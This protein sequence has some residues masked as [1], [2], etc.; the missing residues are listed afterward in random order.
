MPPTETMNMLTTAKRIRKIGPQHHGRKMLLKD[1]E[2]VETVDG[3]HYELSR[4]YITVSNVANFYHAIV[5]AAI[6]NYFGAHQLANPDQIFVIL[7]EMAAKLLIAEFE[8]ER[9]PD[10]AVYLTKPKG[11]KNRTVWRRWIPEIVIEVV[12]A[13]S[14]HRDYFEKRDEYWALGVKEY[15]IVDGQ[16]GVIICLRRGKADWIEKRLGA[17][18]TCTTKLLP[19]FKLPCQA[20]F[21]IAAQDT[22]DE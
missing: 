19:G 14:E 17:A 10:I 16:R 6:R 2:F 4:G 5:V 12:S 21:E 7:T 9:H 11:P 20:I 22:Q 1:Y 3:Y 18:D 8:S 13:R 15:W